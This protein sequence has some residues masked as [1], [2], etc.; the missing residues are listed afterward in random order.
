MLRRKTGQKSTTLRVSDLELDQLKH[1]VKR[2]EKEIT[3]TGKEYGLL[4]YLMLNAGQV[5]TRTMISEH[6]WN[7]DFDSFTNVV[8]VYISRLRNKI[9]KDAKKPLIHSIRGAGYTLKE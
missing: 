8:D 9:D 4:E 6:V 2:G 3:L 1:H 5:V 7:E